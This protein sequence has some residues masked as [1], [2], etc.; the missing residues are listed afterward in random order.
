MARQ[1]IRPYEMSVWGLQD[2]FIITLS[3]PNITHKGQIID[4]VLTNKDDGTQELSFSIPMYYFH[5][6]E[7]IE[8]SLWLKIMQEYFG[9]CICFWCSIKCVVLLKLMNYHSLSIS[10]ML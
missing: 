5:N 1:T 4:P 7:M 10:T 3:A 9:T 8:N 2:D 6:N